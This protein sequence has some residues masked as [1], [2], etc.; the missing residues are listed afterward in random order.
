MVT[1][2]NLHYSIIKGIIDNGFAPDIDDLSKALKADQSE[3]VKGLYDLREYHGVVLHPNEPKVWVIHPFSLAPT[4]FY[5]KSAKGEWW[6]NCAWCSLGVAALLK[7]DVKI[8]T[9]I[10]AET[11]QIEI[12]IIDGEIREKNYFVHFPIP[13]KNAWDNVI[14]TCSNMLVFES[15]EQID[16]WTTK[17]NIK[18]GDI[19]PIDKIWQFSK[20]WY[21][22]HLNPEWTKWTIE[23]AKEMFEEF[24]LSDSIWKLDDSGERF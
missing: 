22:N 4:N 10:G 6:G 14:Y 3:I 17:H 16:R 1:N 24:E 20:K 12:N 13:M 19:Q 21:G 5:M 18:K 15:E 2:S 7:D 8:T 11:K 9:T 23:E